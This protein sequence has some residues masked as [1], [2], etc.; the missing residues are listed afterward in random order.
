MDQLLEVFG[1]GAVFGALAM[2]GYLE[3]GAAFTGRVDAELDDAC[4]G[5]ELEDGTIDTGGC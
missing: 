4:A 1:K 3:T 2:E 5:C